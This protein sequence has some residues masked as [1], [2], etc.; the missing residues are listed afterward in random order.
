MRSIVQRVSEARVTVD[1]QVTASI[2]AGLL[3]LIGFTRGDGARQSAWM[4]KKILD[5]RIVGDNLSQNLFEASAE[6]LV[7]SQFTL[8]ADVRRGRRPDFSQALPKAAA[9]DLYQQFL[10]DLVQLGAHPQTGIFGANM[11]VHLINWGPFT[12]CLERET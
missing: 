9:R 3:V 6:L 1:G 10:N 11:Q 4:A 8:Y 2:Q 12:L 7:V 5:L